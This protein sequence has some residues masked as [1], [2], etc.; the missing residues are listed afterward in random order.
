MFF[1]GMRRTAIFVF[2]KKH[3]MNERLLQYI[4][5]FR[6]FNPHQLLTTSGEPVRVLFPGKL[7]RNQGPDFLESRIQ[8]GTTTWIGHVEL[9]IRSTDWDRHGHQQDPNYRNVI[10]H[11]VWEQDQNPS[12]PSAAANIPTLE[13]KERVTVLLLERYQSLMNTQLFVPCEKHIAEVNDLVWIAWRERL[14]VE[15]LLRTS[16][17]LKVFLQKNHFH[18]EETCWWMMARNFGIRIN[19]DAFEAIARSIPL[20][21]LARHKHSIHQLEALLLGQAGLL[22]EEFE[23]EYPKL[24]KR[25]YR[26]LKQ[27]YQ[28]REA[29][30]TVSFLRMRPSAFP[31]VRLAQLAMLVHHSLHLFS[32]LKEA[33]SITELVKL[34]D[35]T[36]ND[37]WHYHYVLHQ[38]S[39][40]RAK[41]L[42]RQMVENILINTVVPLLFTYGNYCNDT[43]YSDKAITWLE[44][45]SAERNHIITNWSA[46]G[47]IPKNAAESQ[48]LIE[49]KNHYCDH[50]RCL[51]CAVG[52][53]ICSSRV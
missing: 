16:V 19:A 5:Q 49:L 6:H 20:T 35:I 8:I 30:I 7:N 45:L 12:K 53:T 24:L 47:I 13:L 39:A 46:I 31:T 10:L 26:F 21:V 33:N 2:L 38:S 40:F 27:K 52:V 48:A 50:K 34:F 42:G 36:A 3:D 18:W 51:D 43:H 15:R 9:H 32:L 11:V 22:N 4:W 14:L 17:M 37:Y 44:A 1:Y 23:D 29:D 41:H 25:E 28:L